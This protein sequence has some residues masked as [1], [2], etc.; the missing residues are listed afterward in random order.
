M[1]ELRKNQQIVQFGRGLLILA[2]TL[3]G[4]V[5]ASPAESPAIELLG[6]VVFA[7]EVAEPDDVSGVSAVGADF[8]VLGAD[9]GA[10]LQVLQRT[11]DRYQVVS[12]QQM[13]AGEAEVD[14]E[15]IA[16]EGDSVYVVGSHAL[17]RKPLKEGVSLAENRQ[18]LAKVEPKPQRHRLER[19]RID[20]QGR[21]QGPLATLNLSPLIA[22]DEVLRRFQDIPSKE[23]GVDIEGLA[24]RGEV[25]WVGFRGPVLRDNYVP[26]LRLTLAQPEQAELLWVRLDG[27]GV[28]G[29]VAIREGFWLLAGPVGDGDP[30]VRLYFWDGKNCLPGKDLPPCRI[31][32]WGT[33][34]SPPDRSG[35][36]AEGITVL[37]ELEQSYEVLV[38]YDGA[39]SGTPTR[40]RVRKPGQP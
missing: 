4:G 23:N 16:S 5:T 25:L 6:P 20:E 14:L 40:F 8:L 13:V 37:L 7:G 33:I 15:D 1:Q 39:P 26:I 38:V 35:A 18:R 30:A 11:A 21:L 2:W 27:L 3:S 32:L 9:E 36:K 17:V 22:R 24:V 34:P 28:R 10:A 12:T 29:M 31:A 19:W